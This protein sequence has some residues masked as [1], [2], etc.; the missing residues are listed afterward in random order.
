MKNLTGKIENAELVYFSAEAVINPRW[1]L[2][3]I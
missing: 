1:S 2:C 3:Q